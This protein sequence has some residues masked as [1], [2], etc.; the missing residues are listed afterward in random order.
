MA[1][2]TSAI[3]VSDDPGFDYI[4]CSEEEFQGE[5]ITSLGFYEPYK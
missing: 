2:N 5:L 3:V 1:R 4:S